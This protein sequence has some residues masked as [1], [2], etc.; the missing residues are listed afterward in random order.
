MKHGQIIIFYGPPGSG[1]GTQAN[2]LCQRTKIPFLDAGQTFRNFAKIHEKNPEDVRANRSKRMDECL[3]SGN[4]ILTEDYMFIIG[5]KVLETV[6]SGNHLI[7]D[8][9]GGSLIPE[10]EWM[11]D[12]IKKNKFP[13]IFIHLPISIEESIK[14]VETR[15]YVPNNSQVFSNIL[16]AKNFIK[17]NNLQGQ[18]YQRD[19]DMNEE[20]IKNRYKKLYENNKD[21]I[22]EI[23]KNNENVVFYELDGSKDLHETEN[24]VKLIVDKYLK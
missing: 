3:K 19:D 2:L 10:A 4:P 23:F 12:L 20:A 1:K 8:K 5:E 15:W 11:D 21:K 18:P 14:R 24:E 9:P 6:K 7:M 16:D 17:E 13:V 22:L